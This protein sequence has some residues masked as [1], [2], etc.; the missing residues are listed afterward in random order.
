MKMK[1]PRTLLTLAGTLVV[2]ALSLGHALGD[3]VETK[4][5]VTVIPKLEFREMAPAEALKAISTAT[6]IKV[7][8]T[9][10][11]GEQPSITVSLTN[12]PASEALKY[13]TELGNLKFS[14]QEDGV[15]VSPK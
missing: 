1:T 2:A 10:A 11:N 14:Y 4:A 3:T 13:V 8:F 15:H 12:V 6:G 9:P 5:K 7:F